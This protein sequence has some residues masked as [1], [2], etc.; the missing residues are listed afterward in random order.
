MPAIPR[1]LRELYYSGGYHRDFAVD[2]TSP[3]AQHPHFSHWPTAGKHW[4]RFNQTAL[5]CSLIPVDASREDAAERA[6]QISLLT[7]WILLTM[8]GNRFCPRCSPRG[9]AVESMKDFFEV[10]AT[11]P[12]SKGA[13]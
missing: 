13:S 10:L 7:L 3:P 12:Q 8:D 6:E 2:Y 9:L 4:L 1:T 5:E 11:P